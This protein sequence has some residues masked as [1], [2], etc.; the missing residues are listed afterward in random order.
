MLALPQTPR[1]LTVP[2]TRPLARFALL[3][4]CL[5]ISLRELHSHTVD[6]PS[7]TAS[8]RQGIVGGH[9]KSPDY[10]RQRRRAVPMT[11]L[12]DGPHPRAVLS[13]PNQHSLRDF[14][15]IHPLTIPIK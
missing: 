5:Q 11:A 14:P 13:R 2:V 7:Q 10:M 12:R 15:P 6:V 8:A 1:F 9:R 3:L 4:L